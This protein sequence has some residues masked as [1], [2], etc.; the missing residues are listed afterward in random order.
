MTK[1]LQKKVRAYLGGKVSLAAVR[2][3]AEPKMTQL[4]D[5]PDTGALAGAVFGTLWTLDD[6]YGDEEWLRQEP[7]LVLAEPSKVL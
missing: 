2:A 7:R 3:W 6:G 4:F 5:H 1:D